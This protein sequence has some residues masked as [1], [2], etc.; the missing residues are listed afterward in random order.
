MMINLDWTAWVYIIIAFVSTY[1][2]VLFSWWW[3]RMGRATEIYVYLTIMF[4]GI[5]I[6]AGIGAYSRVWHVLSEPYYHQFIK[7]FWWASGPLVV[8]SVLIAINVRMTRRV[9]LSFKY[10]SFAKHDRRIFIRCSYCGRPVE[11]CKHCLK[12]QH[13][14][15]MENKEVM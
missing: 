2:F 14:K 10:K 8:L 15:Q 12:E 5:G 13:K 11:G 4:L 6:S 3:W 7:S 1:G 9:Y